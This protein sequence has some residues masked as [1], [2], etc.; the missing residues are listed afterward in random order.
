MH[1]IPPFSLP[2]ETR[3]WVIIKMINERCITLDT[4]KIIL[5]LSHESLYEKNYTYIITIPIN[6]SPWTKRAVKVH[7]DHTISCR[8][9]PWPSRETHSNC[10]AHIWKSQCNLFI[11][12]DNPISKLDLRQL[13]SPTQNFQQHFSFVTGSCLEVKSRLGKE[14]NA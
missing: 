3:V 14:V 7:R 6:L 4:L 2:F 11:C 1:S 9:V 10:H 8:F 13:C 5:H 12:I